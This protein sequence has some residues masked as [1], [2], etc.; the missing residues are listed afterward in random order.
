MSYTIKIVNNEDGEVVID[1]NNALAIIGGI[2]A[3]KGEHL[4]GFTDCN[5]FKLAG[6]IFAAQKTIA[7]LLK[8]TPEVKML[9]Q[10]GDLAKSF[11]D[12]TE[13]EE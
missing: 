5:S 2:G 12:F 3:E 6:T 4:I 1:E 7:T 11:K 10:L 8:Q 13:S 9:V